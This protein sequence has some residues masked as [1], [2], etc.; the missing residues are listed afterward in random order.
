MDA[1]E[2]KAGDKVIWKDHE[3]VV[4]S[5]D[6]GSLLLKNPATGSKI[7]NVKPADVKPAAK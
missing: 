6:K 3:C 5:N 2:I 1:K 4:V 7:A